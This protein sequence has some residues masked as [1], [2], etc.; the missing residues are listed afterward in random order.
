MSKSLPKQPSLEH[1]KNEAKALLRQA[2]AGDPGALSQVGET[3][4]ANAQLAVARD[5]GFASWA[6]LKRAVQGYETEKAALFA[7]I[8]AGDREGVGR[9]LDAN[10]SLI[11]SYEAESFGSPPIVV[12]ARRDDRPTIDLLLSR[13]ADL[14]ARSDWWAGSFGALDLVGEETAKYLLAKG[15]TLTAHAAARLGMEEALRDILAKNPEVVHERGGDGQYPLHFAKTPEIVDIILDAGADIDA[16]DIDHEGT[17]AQTLILNEPVLRRLVERGAKT[18]LF[19]AIALDDLDLVQKHLDEDPDSIGR[20]IDMPGN[21]MIPQAPGQH[22]YTYNLGF[23]RPFQAAL[24]LNKPRVYDYLFERSPAGLRLA[25]ACCRGDR[26][27]AYRILDDNPSVAAGLPEEDKVLLC[28]S[29][30]TPNPDAVRLMLE[31]GFDPNTQDRENFTV[32]HWASFHGRDDLMEIILPYRPDL[33]LRNV[34]G[35]TVLTTMMFGSRNRWYENGNY[36][37]ALEL[38]IAAGAKLPEKL[39]GSEEVVEVLKRHGVP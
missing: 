32:A 9:A 36:A 16:R 20:G 3:R 27:A 21:P 13:G 39:G 10:P 26:D 1:L 33:E 38:L 22:I 12:A 2:K 37:R 31:V 5:Y 7:A 24:K 6:K 30:R 29:G 34:Y 14:D 15:A 4:L 35:G 23:V 19:I 17:A 11:A 28:Y 25:A 8:R 18:D